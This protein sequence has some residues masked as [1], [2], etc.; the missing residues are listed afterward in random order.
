MWW[1][2]A[3]VCA[4]TMVEGLLG[5]QRPSVT[6]RAGSAGHCP[7]LNNIHACCTPKRGQDSHANEQV[8]GH[9]TTTGPGKGFLVCVADHRPLR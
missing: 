8:A 5:A 2:G 6:L 3:G 1:D 7:S 9:I 4:E